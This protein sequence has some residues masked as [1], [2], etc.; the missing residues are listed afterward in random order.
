MKGTASMVSGVKVPK[1]L[2]E[3]GLEIHDEPFWD[4]IDE[5]SDAYYAPAVYHRFFGDED[6]SLVEEAMIYTYWLPW[7]LDYLDP[8]V[9]LG[10]VL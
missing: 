9:D 1:T 7:Q 6:E 3:Y 8:I 10:V 5:M 2:F 4:V